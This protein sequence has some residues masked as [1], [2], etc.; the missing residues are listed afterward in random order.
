M[1]R[2]AYFG[3]GLMMAFLAHICMRW[4]FSEG[5]GEVDWGGGGGGGGELVRV[6]I[7]SGG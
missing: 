2:L 3:L 1:V 5:E 4:R 7:R 6:G